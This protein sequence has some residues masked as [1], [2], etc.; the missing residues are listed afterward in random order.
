MPRHLHEISNR[1]CGDGY[2]CAS[3]PV[4][5]ENKQEAKHV[6]GRQPVCLDR[7]STPRSSTK[8]LSMKRFLFFAIVLF[9]LSHL[10]FAQVA[11]N[12]TGD[13]PDPSAML[14]I[15]ASDKGLLIPRV[16]LTGTTD[17]TTIPSPATGLM[18]YNTAT[19][20][21]VVE[22]FYY[23][24]GTKWQRLGNRAYHFE[25]GLTDNG[26][27][28]VRF[29]GYLSQNTTLD[30][31][32]NTLYFNLDNTG[33][34]IIQSD[35]TD[36]IVFNDN[37]NVEFKGNIV[38]NEYV[39]LGT[40]LGST[41]YGFRTRAGN[42][43]Y[44]RNDTSQ[45]S[46]FPDAVPSG[47]TP[48]WWYKPQDSTFIRPLNNDNIRIYDDNE[49]YGFYYDGST[50]QYGGFFRTQSAAD[51]TSAV[52][53]F[54]DIA[55]L[56]TYGYL[57]Y[58]GNYTNVAGDL[59]LDG[60]AV[61]GKVDDKKRAAIF[62]RT[63]RDATIA[64]IVGYSD[65]WI[66][67]YFYSRDNDERSASHPALYG[68]TLVDVDKSG[69]QAAVEGWSEYIAGTGNR[70]YT[71]GGDFSAVGHEQDAIGLNIY[72]QSY[73]SN[74][75][76]YGAYF[77]V[78]SAETAYG[79]KVLAGTQGLSSNV[80][81]VYSKARTDKGI[82]II[83]V[84]SNAS[85]FFSSGAGDGVIGF[86]DSG[87]GVLGYY[88]DDPNDMNNYGVLG[89]DTYV[90]NYF[91]H[92]ET[93]TDDGQ[94]TISVERETASGNDGTDYKMTTSNK[95]I[96]AINY[97][98]DNYSFAI[99]GYGYNNG[100]RTG[101]V[102]GGLFDGSYNITEWGALGYAAS[103]GYDYGVYY[104]TLGSGSGKGNKKSIG[105]G[106]YSDNIGGW[107][108]GKNYGLV[109]KSEKNSLLV[110]GNAYT[111]GINAKITKDKNNNQIVSYYPTSDL[112]R[113]I[114]SGQAKLSQ[115]KASITFKPEYQQLIS[116]D[117][118]II[119]TLT[120]IGKSN[121][122][123]LESVSE[124]GFKVAENNNG[125]SN[126]TFNWIAIAITKDVNT[127]IDQNILSNE[128]E[129]IIT[130]EA[131]Q[132]NNTENTVIQR[133]SIKKEQLKFKNDKQILQKKRK[134]VSK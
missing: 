16:A 115:G 117:Y 84:G 77:K 72:A 88:D 82:G 19:T 15:S 30:F 65:V 35:G 119:I 75:L 71:V 79:I 91:Y 124:K 52:V 113:I 104:T 105:L 133:K 118:P 24:D 8:N 80:Y 92:N 14:D 90:A 3:D 33:D 67:G 112:P 39:N 49:K 50:N 94:A 18:I 87:F 127:P 68:Q 38:V 93:Q 114:F 107:I 48:I 44:K 81:G 17:N 59:S 53:G 26:S 6:D 37:G 22:G 96:E 63:T 41:G 11:I 134:N 108:Y 76:A 69:Y 61:Y 103:N 100:Y 86:S 56:Q 110:L 4:A 54:S 122:L 97:S 125:K 58:S 12:T 20:S 78:D 131:V 21:D 130:N 116:P 51:T 132:K 120:P 9:F 5:S 85:D 32:F 109:L 34:F 29:G 83:G 62:G 40:I 89:Y 128:I 99:A 102:W 60:S 45:W 10:T 126:I 42:L 43:E 57:G 101:G 46:P 123:Y 36:K 74:T 2:G 70:G 27:G 13:S 25:N 111:T 129:N 1:G 66:A 64:A 98:A 7:G 31:G 23:Y 95:A 47:A 55:G 106:G 121:G 73:G 28:T